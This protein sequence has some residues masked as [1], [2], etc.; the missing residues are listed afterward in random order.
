MISAKNEEVK[1][2]MG[3]Y[4]WDK[5]DTVE[6]CW[7]VSISF[8]RK[9]GYFSE[10]CSMSGT[11]SW[12]N[13][14]DEQVAS[15]SVTIST[16]D[17]EN[18]IRFEYAITDHHSKEKTDY[19]YKV[20][21]QTTPCN[22]G[23]ARYWFTCPLSVN[24]VDCGRRV[25]KLYLVPGGNYFGCRHCYNLSYESRNKT[26]SGMLGAFGGVLKADKQIE[27]LRSQIKR[28]TY[29][30][31]PTQKARKLQALERRMNVYLSMSERFLK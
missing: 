27:E 18:Y 10:P 28:W 30:R 11:I 23:G 3:G 31:K 15:I 4:Y 22:F 2:D 5:K 25:A 24:G 17:G 26:R 21:L 19:D 9:H 7:S 1:K 6:D 16:M 8:L 13:C 29:K 14:Y 20:A 12:K